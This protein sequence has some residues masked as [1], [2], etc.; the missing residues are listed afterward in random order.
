MI[1]L[2]P[3]T[4]GLSQVLC[5]SNRSAMLSSKIPQASG[6]PRLAGL[7]WNC[8][9]RCSGRNNRAG[10]QRWVMRVSIKQWRQA[11]SGLSSTSAPPPAFA[12][13]LH[14]LQLCEPD[15]SL[16]ATDSSMRNPAP[17]RKGM[18]S[19]VFDPTHRPLD[20]APAQGYADITRYAARKI[21]HLIPQLVSS[22]TQVIVPELIHFL[23]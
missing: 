10:L 8:Q 9:R 15:N 6:S 20:L 3:M 13:G 11:S 19:I 7:Y 12:H 22:L 1:N 17:Y 5:A 21:H 23:R 2:R 4:G 16:A 18:Q 14:K